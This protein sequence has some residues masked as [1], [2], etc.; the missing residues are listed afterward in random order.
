[1]F[2]SPFSGESVGMIALPLSIIVGEHSLQGLLVNAPDPEHHSTEWLADHLYQHYRSDLS[3]ANFVIVRP[4]VGQVMHEYDFRERVFPSLRERIP[5]LPV[6]LL[7][8]QK[9]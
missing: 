7:G 8:S 9:C 6:Y 4:P 2:H 3:V 5:S 1:M